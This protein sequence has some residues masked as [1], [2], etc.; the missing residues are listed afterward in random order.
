MFFKKQINI[1]CFSVGTFIF[2]AGVFLSTSRGALFSL[3]FS[4]FIILFMIGT[5]KH[6]LILL[7]LLISFI[8]LFI[9]TLSCY[10]K[11]LPRIRIIY[12][13]IDYIKNWDFKGLYS[14]GLLFKI[15]FNFSGREGI[16]ERGLELFKKSPLI[17]IGTGS[18]RFVS[19][20]GKIHHLHDIF[21]DIMVEQG[22]IGLIIFLALISYLSYLSFKI[23]KGSFTFYLLIIIVASQVFDYFFDHSY[24]YFI[25]T[26]FLFGNILNDSN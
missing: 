12:P 13:G 14:K 3:V 2:L 17:G 18:Y 20:K 21:L 7:F 1:V 5:K 15:R 19:G 6:K 8:I 23:R 26:S 11:L 25:L 10:P 9:F 16:W 22:I 4:L 24:F